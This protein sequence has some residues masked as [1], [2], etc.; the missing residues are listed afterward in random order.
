M[1]PNNEVY[2]T[3]SAFWGSP[4]MPYNCKLSN[5]PDVD[6]DVGQYFISICVSCVGKL[7]FACSRHSSYKQSIYRLKYI[8]LLKFPIILSGNSF[9]FDLLFP[10]L[11]LTK[12]TLLA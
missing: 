11:F 2:L 6:S 1:C 5:I 10:K 9:L 4:Y 7:Q 8:M 3:K 12:I